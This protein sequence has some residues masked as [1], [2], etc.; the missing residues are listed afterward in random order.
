MATNAIKPKKLG[1]TKVALI[2]QKA[3]QSKETLMMTE[4]KMP[5]RL[6]TPKCPKTRKETRPN[7]QIVPKKTLKDR[8]A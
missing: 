3:K 4:L 1:L 5:K 7:L 8:K 6:K 2:C